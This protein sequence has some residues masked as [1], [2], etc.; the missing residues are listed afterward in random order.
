[1]FKDLWI[2]L[3]PWRAFC[4]ARYNTSCELDISGLCDWVADSLWWTDPVN[5]WKVSLVQDGPGRD[6]VVI[7]SPA[8]FGDRFR[9]VAGG[10]GLEPHKWFDATVDDGRSLCFGAESERFFESL[11][12]LEQVT[13]LI[14]IV[15]DEQAMATPRLIARLPKISK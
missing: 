9:I 14:R 8:D 6:Q 13:L 4:D 11:S 1:M 10:I 3:R 5:G 12:G 7:R 15:D 2:T